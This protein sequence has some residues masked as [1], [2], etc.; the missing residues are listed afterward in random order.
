[1]NENIKISFQKNG[2]QFEPF[3]DTK[4]PFQ[5]IEIWV[6]GLNQGDLLSFFGG[7]V[8]TVH[9]KQLDIQN[10]GLVHVTILLA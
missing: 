5:N 10:G 7:P 1:M 6:A 8:F 9:G 3:P 2:K 4:N